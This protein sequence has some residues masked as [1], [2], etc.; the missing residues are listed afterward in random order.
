MV[1]YCRSIYP[2]VFF[3]AAIMGMEDLKKCVGDY[4]YRD[5]EPFTRFEKMID[6]KG[7]YTGIEEKGDDEVLKIARD[8]LNMC[9]AYYIGATKNGAPHDLAFDEFFS[10]CTRY[11]KYHLDAL[12]GAGYA[13]CTL[14]EVEEGTLPE[15]IDEE[16]VK[17]Y[18][19]E[20]F[21][22]S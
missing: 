18:I 13:F 10:F 6:K 12:K 16:A 5:Y 19:S 7:Y 3:G 1:H 11:K 17:G 21:R 2:V 20:Y 4:P 9:V 14:L 8:V 22:K 15:Q